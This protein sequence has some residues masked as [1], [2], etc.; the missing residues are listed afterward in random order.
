MIKI[1]NEKLEVVGNLFDL[2]GDIAYVV[3]DL[4]QKIRKDSG[5]IS[6]EA[7]DFFERSVLRALVMGRCKDID[8]ASQVLDDKTICKTYNASI[9]EV[10]KILELIGCFLDKEVLEGAEND[11]D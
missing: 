11:K 6:K 1:E 10:Q 5:P 4:S 7:A 9:D 2:T 8:K 3:A